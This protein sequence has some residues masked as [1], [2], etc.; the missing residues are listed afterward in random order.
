MAKKIDNDDDDDVL[1]VDSSAT[2]PTTARAAVSTRVLY[3]RAVNYS[4]IFCYYSSPR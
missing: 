3:T 1:N 2:P 4:N